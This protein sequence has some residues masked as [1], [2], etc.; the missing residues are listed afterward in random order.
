MGDDLK[1]VTLERDLVNVLN[2]SGLPILVK[3]MILEKI[4]ETATQKADEV[5]KAQAEAYEKEKE[6]ETNGSSTDN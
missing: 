1:I 5:L 2:A 3:K 4:L 6:S